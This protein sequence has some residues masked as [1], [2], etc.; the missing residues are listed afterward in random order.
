MNETPPNPEVGLHPEY[1]YASDHVQ[2]NRRYDMKLTLSTS[3]PVFL[4]VLLDSVSASLL[5]RADKPTKD[6]DPECTVTNPL[7]N[8]FYDLRPLI[9]HGSDQ[10][11]AVLE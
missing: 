6:P 8:E 5:Q 10:Y 3:L 11:T 2:G 4:L 9:R 7:T 1:S